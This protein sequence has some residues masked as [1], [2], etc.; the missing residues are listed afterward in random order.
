MQVV[1]PTSDGNSVDV[2]YD[3]SN[4]NLD[5]WAN[6]NGSPSIIVATGFIAKN[7]LARPKAL[8][9]EARNP[10]FSQSDLRGARAR[11]LC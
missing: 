9:P 8:K 7:P 5:Q 4:A 1:T 6:D 10:V 2:Q 3:R 11:E